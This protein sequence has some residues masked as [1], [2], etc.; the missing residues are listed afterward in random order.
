[1]VPMWFASSLEELAWFGLVWFFHGF[2]CQ[3]EMAVEFCDFGGRKRGA[4]G[5]GGCSIEEV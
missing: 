1:M 5:G 3:T 2:W 4:R